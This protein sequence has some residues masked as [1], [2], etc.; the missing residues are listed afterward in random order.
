[1]KDEIL[2]DFEKSLDVT[3][4][5]LSTTLEESETLEFKSSLQVKSDTIDKQYLKTISAFANN[6]GGTIIFGIS[7]EKEVVGIKAEFENLDNRY[8][9]STINT[10]LDGS[11]RYSFLTKNFLGKVVGFL[12]VEKAITRPVIL[13]VDSAEF[14]LGEIYFRYP[15][16]TS[17]IMAS[18]LRTLIAEEISNGVNKVVGNINKLIEIGE[19]AAILDTK[20]GVIDTGNRMPKFV[21][22]E[23]IL[24]NLNIIKLGEFVEKEGSPAYVIKGEIQTGNLDHM[25]VIEKQVPSNLYERDILKYFTSGKCEC[26]LLV[27]EKLITLSSQYFPIHFFINEHGF[28]N[29]E[30]IDHLN[31]VD[32]KVINSTTKDKIIERLS[33]DYDYGIHGVIDKDITEVLDNG[34]ITKQLLSAVSEKYKK[35]VSSNSKVKRSLIYNSLIEYA[36]ISNELLSKETT[37]VTT[38]LTNITA[39]ILL[40]NKDYFLA[41]IDRIA[42]TGVKRNT[43]FKKAVC[44]VDKVLYSK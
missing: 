23:K 16:Q 22:D 5:V 3:K 37:L 4:P 13:K 10:G 7:P 33:I 18:D 6:A 2:L 17:K 9:S 41:L 1:M 35:P 20:S 29:K 44:F 8:I 28:T 12:I 32:E 36:E 30:V 42:E 15:A 40:K 25:E 27:L 39:E 21:L 11:F 38:A 43:S 26:P 31:S 14:K 24:A 19:N 34:N